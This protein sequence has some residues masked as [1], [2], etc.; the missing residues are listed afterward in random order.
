MHPVL[1]NNSVKTV[2]GAAEREDAKM[3]IRVNKRVVRV[4]TFLFV[5]GFLRKQGILKAREPQMEKVKSLLKGEVSAVESVS[6]TPLLDLG[7]TLVASA[8]SRRSDQ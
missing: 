2:L 5:G 7:Y 4:H 3:E 1:V 8:K 6:G